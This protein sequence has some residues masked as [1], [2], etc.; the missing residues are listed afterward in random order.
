[1]RI[2]LL[3]RRFDSAGGGTE[4]DLIVTAQVPARGGPS[5]YDFRRRDPRRDRRLGCSSRRR[6]PKAGT[7]P[8]PDAIR[9]DCRACGAP[10]RRRPGAE[11]RAMRRRG[12]DA[13]RRRRACQLPPRG[14]K[15]ARRARRVGDACQPVSSGA[16][17]GRA[18]GLPKSRPEARD[19]GVEFRSRRSDSGIRPRARKNGYDLQRRRSRS[20]P[21]R[22]RSVRARGYPP[23][24]C[25]FR[26]C[27]D[28]RFCR[29]WLYARKGL[30]F[31]IEDMAAGRGRR[32]FAGGRRRSSQTGKFAAPRT[33][34]PTSV[35]E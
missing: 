17:A 2:A 9:M 13:L 35:L 16:D 31:L 27:P 1:M 28:G 18:P 32:V 19:R 5:N 11:L 33:T 21:A 30:G 20:L 6:R 7:R 24:V 23:E 22:R 26:Q 10:R 8:V 29:Q 34:P 15:M 4:R 14:A 25:G 12:R 3:T